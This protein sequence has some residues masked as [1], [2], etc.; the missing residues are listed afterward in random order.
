MK[1]EDISAADRES[2]WC[3]KMVSGDV[4]IYR[5][6]AVSATDLYGIKYDAID[7]GESERDPVNEMR[8]E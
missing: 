8:D 3:F 6:S 2:L 4:L 7:F 1:P 5:S